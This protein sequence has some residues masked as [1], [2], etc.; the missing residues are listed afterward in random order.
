MMRKGGMMADYWS[1][2]YHPQLHNARMVRSKQNKNNET[3]YCTYVFGFVL[4]HCATS[5]AFSQQMAKPLPNDKE[6]ISSHLWTYSLAGIWD[7][8]IFCVPWLQNTIWPCTFI[9]MMAL[10]HINVKHPLAHVS[11]P[12]LHRSAAL[13]PTYSP[14]LRNIRI[15]RI[16]SYWWRSW[17]GLKHL[18][19]GQ[20]Q[21]DKPQA[22]VVYMYIVL[23]RRS[24]PPLNQH[25][26]I[27]FFRISSCNFQTIYGQVYKQLNTL[28]I[29]WMSDEQQHNC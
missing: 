24:G 4:G 11:C 20:L 23:T 18:I 15:L 3:A 28:L 14:Q 22:S 17:S 21:C 29:A 13:T 27:S 25:S 16:W 9:F 7:K 19:Q 6:T 12:T 5:K 10:T 8:P 1:A 26:L 2:L